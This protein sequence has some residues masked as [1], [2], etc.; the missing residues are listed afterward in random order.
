M[1]RDI[2]DALFAVDQ[3]AA[4]TLLRDPGKTDLFYGFDIPA[5][6]TPTDD[7]KFELDGLGR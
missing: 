5:R 1:K 3:T 2:H 6:S 4:Q 7:S